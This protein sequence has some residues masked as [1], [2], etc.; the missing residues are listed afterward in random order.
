MGG[1]EAM[2]ERADQTIGTETEK[3]VS[4]WLTV[5]VQR[6]AER[7]GR[8]WSQHVR[9]LSQALPHCMCVAHGWSVRPMERPRIRTARLDRFAFA[10]AFRFGAH[11]GL[12][13]HPC[14]R[15]SGGVA[16]REV[17]DVGLSPGTTAA[18]PGDEIPGDGRGIARGP[19]RRS[20]SGDVVCQVPQLFGCHWRSSD[21]GHALHNPLHIFITF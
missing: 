8:D 6:A 19:V 1:A 5:T 16:Q 18:T 17:T 20:C 14:A 11:P 12:I 2:G 15:R 4:A 9:G 10:A 13:V 7:L 3:S 21:I